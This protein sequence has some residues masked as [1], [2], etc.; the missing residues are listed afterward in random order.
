MSAL[1]EIRNTTNSLLIN[2]GLA[3]GM[4]YLKENL[5]EGTQVY[6]DFIYDRSK[7]T[8]LEYKRTK[9]TEPPEKLDREE[10]QIREAFIK[11]VDALSEGDIKGGEAEEM[12]ETP[13]I[14]DWQARRVY[15]EKLL[16]GKSREQAK[17]MLIERI[18]QMNLYEDMG[19]I[20]LVNVNRKKQIDGIW[21]AFDDKEPQDF[22]YYFLCACRQQMPQSLA[23]RFLFELMHEEL[24]EEMEA[25]N[26]PRIAD[27]LR[28]DFE[29]WEFKNKLKR[30]WK[31]F[32]KILEERFKDRF[33]SLDLESFVKT[34]IPHMEERY[35]LTSIT[36]HESDWSDH[37]KEFFELLMDTFT[38]TDEK[39]PTFLFFFVIYLDKYEDEPLSKHQ[40]HILETVAS[41]IEK[42]PAACSLHKGLS[43]ISDVDMITWFDKLGEDNRE[44]IFGV[45]DTYVAGLVKSGHDAY[46]NEQRMNM[47][48]ME[49][50][51][52]I[53]YKQKS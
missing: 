30:S 53:V 19:E 22:Q 38:N 16:K 24:D 8:D 45:L 34:G 6:Q 39:C 11:L 33:P 4:D 21:D 20:Q 25:I 15:M 31:K 48:I 41:L 3:S 10:N 43:P 14:E 37:A 17:S 50:L 44:K 1:E 5:K 27:S 29:K 12:E 47:D 42:Y 26:Y 2:E 7:L 18:E 28:V 49:V 9:G 35:V 40:S 51:Q 52:E 13:Q 36:F 23:E 32:K 46:W